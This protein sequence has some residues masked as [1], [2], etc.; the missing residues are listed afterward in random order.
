MSRCCRHA[1]W[2][3]RRVSDFTECPVESTRMCIYFLKCFDFRVL[4]INNGHFLV[5]S[6]LETRSREATPSIIVVSP[7]FLVT[8]GVF[9]SPAETGLGFHSRDDS[10]T[11]EAEQSQ[12]GGSPAASLSWQESTLQGAQRPALRDRRGDD[13]SRPSEDAGRWGTSGPAPASPQEP[14]DQRDH[15]Q[16]GVL[17]IPSNC[18]RELL[19]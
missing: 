12:E 4:F 17:R 15:L 13:R 14:G 19:Q 7:Y 10:G 9:A 6:I 5:W 1:G 16:A 11:S 18:Q 8:L 2:R 3:F